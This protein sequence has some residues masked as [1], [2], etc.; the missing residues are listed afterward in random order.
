VRITS[1]GQVTIPRR[2]REEMGFLS[3]T[4]VEFEVRE[5]EVILKKTAPVKG[6]RMSAYIRMMRG[7]ADIAMSTDEI[8]SLT[9]DNGDGAG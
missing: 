8:M 9:R 1:K 6:P 2:I 3:E 5:N 4:E 7:S